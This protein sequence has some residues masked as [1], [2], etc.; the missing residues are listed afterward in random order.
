LVNVDFQIGDRSPLHCTAIGKAILAFQNV[1]F[2]EE[3]IAA[4]LPRRTA[5]T[6]TD[7]EGLRSELH[8]VRSMGYAVDDHE[9]SD[10]MR[11]IAVPLF[12][13]GGLVSGGFSISTPDYRMSPDRIEEL[14]DLLLKASRKFSRQ[15]GG[16]PWQA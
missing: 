15:L 8:R 2:V 7:P 12:E 6:I 5:Y 1:L 13:G 3:V 4:G 11:C 14:R 9:F 16:M 10:T